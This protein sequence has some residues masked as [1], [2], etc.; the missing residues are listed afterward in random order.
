MN[1]SRA[2]VNIVDFLERKPSLFYKG[3]QSAMQFY[4]S[5]KLQPPQPRSAFSAEEPLTAFEHLRDKNEI[6]KRVIELTPGKNIL[7]R[8]HDHYS[9]MN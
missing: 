3:F 7:V 5:N 8:Y 9:L 4:R 6:G 1:T 2:S